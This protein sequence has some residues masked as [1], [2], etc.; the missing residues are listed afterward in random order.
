MNGLH[1]LMQQEPPETQLGEPSEERIPFWFWPLIGI[2]SV[3]FFANVLGW[4]KAD[5]GVNGWQLT[6]F[7]IVTFGFVIAALVTIAVVGKECRSVLENLILAIIL[8]PVVLF[9]GAIVAIMILYL[10]AIFGIGQMKFTPVFAEVFYLAS[11][12]VASIF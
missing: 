4:T 7:Y 11:S 12:V 9:A 5:I 8:P 10:L 3:L 6:F 2:G 1:T